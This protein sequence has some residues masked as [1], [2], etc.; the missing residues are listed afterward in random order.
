MSLP[1][2]DAARRV[3][4]P[5]LFLP[6]L[7]EREPEEFASL[8]EIVA[9]LRE[10]ASGRP[11]SFTLGTVY[12]PDFEPAP[13]I[14]VRAGDDWITSFCNRWD[15]AARGSALMSLRAAA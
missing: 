1:L 10:L 7:P 8:P 9:R 12:Y 15:E 4:R 3:R 11:L 5:T 6:G 14:H 2:L 13:A